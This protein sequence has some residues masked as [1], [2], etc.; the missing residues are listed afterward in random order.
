MIPLWK[1]L[2]LMWPN[3]SR[4]FQEDARACASVEYYEQAGS[5]C[6]LMHIAKDI[7]DEL[8]Q[9]SETLNEFP[10]YEGTY[11]TIWEEAWYAQMFGNTLHEDKLEQGAKDALTSNT[12]QPKP[13]ETKGKGKGKGK[14]WAAAIVHCD[15]DNPFP[16]PMTFRSYGD[17]CPD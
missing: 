3:D 16:I 11:Y 13:W 6:C 8:K 5:L 12:P 7:Q 9:D 17:G 15:S 2:T 14:R 10:G 1:S 4:D